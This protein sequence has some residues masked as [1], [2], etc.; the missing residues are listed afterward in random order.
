MKPRHWI[1]AGSTTFAALAVL[2]LTT[3]V[4]ACPKVPFYELVA[5]VGWL[6]AFEQL[7]GQL[8]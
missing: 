1:V 4:C 6:K 5:E 8:F 2:L 3:K 7:L